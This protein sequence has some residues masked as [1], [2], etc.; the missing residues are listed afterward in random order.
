LP[1]L[2]I[3]GQEL[4]EMLKIARSQ[5]GDELLLIQL[6]P[7]ADFK[8]MWKPGRDSQSTIFSFSAIVTKS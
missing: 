1:E 3:Y 5:K 4:M 2:A 7:Q 8:E 6:T